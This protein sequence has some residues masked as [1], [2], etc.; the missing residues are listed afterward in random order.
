MLSQEAL[1]GGDACLQAAQQQ[2][3]FCLLIEFESLLVDLAIHVDGQIGQAQQ[4]LAEAQQAGFES[5]A[6]AD[7][8]AA[9]QAEIAVGKRRQNRAAV[10]FDAQTQVVFAG[11]CRIGLE[12]KA[13]RI[14]MCADDTESALHQ[15]LVAD[16]ERNQGGAAADDKV[17]PADFKLPAVGFM[18]SGEASGHQVRACGG[19]GVP[20]AGAGIDEIQ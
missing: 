12:P 8:H 3:Q 19:D 1:V 11:V 9:G 16:D 17:A 18:Q 13:G 15:R 4:G 6:V 20:R 7:I 10:D 5:R 14:G 2:G